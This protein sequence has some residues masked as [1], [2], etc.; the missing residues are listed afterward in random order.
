MIVCCSPKVS[1]ML[2]IGGD[3]L[4]FAKFTQQYIYIST[5]ISLSSGRWFPGI[6]SSGGA[7]P[8]ALSFL[9]SR[10][11]GIA[12]GDLADFIYII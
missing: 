2:C 8:D 6:I 1:G 12:P 10:Q 11:A 5:P 3:V 7:G 4:S 9:S